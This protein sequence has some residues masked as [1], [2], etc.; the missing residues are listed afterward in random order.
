MSSDDE[1]RRL[2]VWRDATTQRIPFGTIRRAESFDEHSTQW[3]SLAVLVRDACSLPIVED[4][5]DNVI[6]HCAMLK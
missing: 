4:M 2:L 5:V 6:L 1:S 3:H